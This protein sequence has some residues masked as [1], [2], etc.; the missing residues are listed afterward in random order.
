MDSGHFYKLI[1][2]NR[3][4][5]NL[6]SISTFKNEIRLIGLLCLFNLFFACNNL[7]SQERIMFSDNPDVFI[8]EVQNI[9][10]ISA[11]KAL[12]DQSEIIMPELI[13]RW[14]GVRFNKMEKNVVM[15]IS[16]KMIDENFGGDLIFIEFFD[17]IN[18]I[19]FST[20]DHESISNYLNYTNNLYKTEGKKVLKEHLTFSRNFFEK[21]ILN[22]AY[23]MK[24]YLR[25]SKYRF[26]SSE[27]LLISVD[28]GTIACASMRDS[29]VIEK[30]KGVFSKVDLMWNGYGGKTTWHRF[31]MDENAVFAELSKYSINMKDI[32]YSADSVMFMN[33]KSSEKPVLGR[34]QDKAFVN[35]QKTTIY[36]LFISY[37]DDYNL[38]NV[39]PNIDLY[40]FVGM[41]GPE[42][43][44]FGNEHFDALMTIHRNDSILANL[45]AKTFIIKESKIKADNVMLNLA[46]D[47]D[48]LFHNGL[49]MQYDATKR[50]FDFYNDRKTV[51]S[52]PFYDTY[53]KIN[54]FAGTLNWNVDDNK[55]K[56]NDLVYS[57]QESRAY[58]KSMNYFKNFDWDRIQGMDDRNPLAIVGKYLKKYETNVVDVSFF[59]SYI[60]RNIEQAISMIMRLAEQGYVTYDCDNKIAYP[61]ESLFY[62]IKARNGEV[63][64]DVIK[65][66]SLTK[67]KQPNM[68]FDLA[69]KDLIVYGVENVAV[70][71]T[72]KVN[73]VPYD[74][75]IIVKKNL[76]IEFSGTMMAGMFEFFTHSSLFKY[77]D[78]TIEL[79]TVDSL[80]FYV[81][82]KEKDA[83]KN[84]PEYVRIKNVITDV[85]GIIYIDEKTNKSG[86][87]DNPGYPIFDCVK[88]SHLNYGDMVFILPPFKIDGLFTFRTS[89]FNLK[90]VFHSGIFPDFEDELLV[91]DDY[92]LGFNHK[93]KPSETKLVV[94]NATF[95]NE[96]NLSNEGFYGNGTLNFKTSFVESEHIDFYHDSLVCKTGKFELLAVDNGM[97]SY[98]HASADSVEIKMFFD[99][100]K[101]TVKTLNNS[102]EMYDSS[103]F[104]GIAFLDQSGFSGKGSLNI[105]V[106]NIKSD[107][108]IFKEKVFEADK[109]RFAIVT[110]SGIEAFLASNYWSSVDFDKR[111]GSFKFLDENSKLTFPLNQFECNLLKAGWKMDEKTISISSDY[112]GKFTSTN[113]DQN[114]FSFESSMADY[115]MKNYTINAQDV[116]TITVADARI[117][118]PNRLINVGK[119]ADI[120]IIKDAVIL[121]NNKDNECKFYNAEVKIL[122]KNE[123]RAS[124]YYDYID[125]DKRVTP[126]LFND[127]YCETN[128]VTKASCHVSESDNFLVSRDYL[129]QGDVKLEA[130]RRDL[131]FDGSFLM[132]NSCLNDFQWF[133]SETL[134]NPD[135]IVLP[136]NDPDFAYNSGLYYDDQN[137]EFFATFLS[138]NLMFKP[139]KTVLSHNDE[140]VFDPEN[141]CYKNGKLVLDAQN[142]TIKG[143][144]D[145]DLGFNN[146]FINLTSN[147]KFTYDI[148]MDELHIDVH[149]SLKFLFE[150]NLFGKL[151][152]KLSEWTDD[153]LKNVKLRDKANFVFEDMGMKWVGSMHCFVNEGPIKLLSMKNHYVYTIFDGHLM[154][155][156]NDSPS[157]TLYIEYGENQWVYF[158]YKEEI[159]ASISSDD[160]YNNQLMGIKENKRHFVDRKTDMEYEF[161]IGDF[162]DVNNFKLMMNYLQGK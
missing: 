13:E 29:I 72:K 161:M 136:L 134:I 38:K 135:S 55:L 110:N 4:V 9:M 107:Y 155:N 151:I 86:K 75:K 64:Y 101:L 53:H 130:G 147:G 90:G 2:N 144:G 127:I 83:N 153:S 65:I 20:L 150:D 156:Y 30:T 81:K 145:L 14:N 121:T 103:T 34:L 39:Y 28:D 95:T 68:I 118:I 160:E 23:N 152:S 59:A 1:G 63:D 18:D 92:S 50:E 52:E 74:N 27:E 71:E 11:N 47:G 114:G 87:K 48:S 15:E 19:A 132:I 24:W 16:Q 158:C 138:E 22:V 26:P 17:V 125:G 44:T 85:S 37:R 78:F 137:K 157:L 7:F 124:G 36:P 32:E 129:F 51:E 104:K 108:F 116:D 57:I 21:D 120:G 117:N 25:D 12:K 98:P 100:N 84:I 123:Y 31:K 91:N 133:K 67:N 126:L 61:R 46:L 96:V 62:A 41:Q 112:R 54:I 76:N 109:S 99:D 97:I 6:K 3:V 94:G 70:S 69:S 10:K 149:S 143:E 73:I 102:M 5:V 131:E 43:C 93:L 40:G 111:I 35:K 58:F 80:S 115:D 60:N 42:L 33:K 49:V 106:A 128:G 82:R 79:P 88:D 77:S 119:D 8:S 140:L 141:Q 142:C 146:P 148:G 139:S 45:Y 105:D 154:L 113:P 89:N 159:L 122:S 66:E 162:T 56:F